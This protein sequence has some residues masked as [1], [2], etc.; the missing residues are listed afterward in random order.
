MDLLVP[1]TALAAGRVA[2]GT[3]LTVAPGPF[4]GVWIGRRAK[5]PRTQ[6]MC[7]GLGVRDLVLGVGGVLSL[8]RDDFGRP[9][10][11]YAAQA[12]T[13][14]TDLLAT[15]AAGSALEP[16]RR[17]MIVLLAAG[18][19]AIGSAAALTDVGRQPAAAALD[20]P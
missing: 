16:G 6:I 4:A 14:G 11:W 15:L 8:R 3:G 17:R 5:D 1:A 18:S 2:F 12:L 7:R 13:D 19:A 20:R 9:R 10:W